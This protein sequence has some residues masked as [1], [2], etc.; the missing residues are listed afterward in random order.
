MLIFNLSYEAIIQG[1]ESFK[2]AHKRYEFK[3]VKNGVTIVDDYAHHPVEI[4]ATLSTARKTDHKNIYC[5]FQPHTYT[6]T[7]T[8]F[9]EFSEAFSDCDEL[10]LMDIYAAR[11]KDTGLVNSVELGDAIRANGVKCTN[12]HSHEEALNYIT[13]KATDKDL[14]LTVG[15][16]DVVRV[17]EMFL[18]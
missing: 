10:I 14:V 7:K 1:L 17:G 15:A 8:L 13:S 12:V 16:G 4:K 2:G 3:G 5:V 9:N 11:E 6:R 18:K